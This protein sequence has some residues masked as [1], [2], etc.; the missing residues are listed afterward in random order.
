MLGIPALGM[1][2]SVYGTN[3]IGTILF[4][5]QHSVNLPY[6]Q[7]GNTWDFVKAAIEG[8]TFVKIPILFKPFTNG[9]EYHHIHHLNT[10]VPSYMIEECHHSFE[11]EQD[12]E[13]GTNWDQIGINQV[14]L[15][16]AFKSVF[17]VMLDEETST[18]RPFDYGWKWYGI[19][20]S[21]LWAKQLNI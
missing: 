17:N 6:R 9:I 11:G 21:L 20:F 2:I 15:G 19:L 18:L 10:M 7:R 3:I 13:K 14:G 12:P 4:H 16:L 5:L 1:W 8:S